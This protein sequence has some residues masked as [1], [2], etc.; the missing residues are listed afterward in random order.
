MRLFMS[1]A[2]EDRDPAEQI[3]LALGP[4]H[5]VFFDRDALPPGGDF[6]TR[7]RAAIA[8]A[9]GMIF[10]ISPDSVQAGSYTLT[11]L[12][13]AR[14]NWGHPLGRVLPVM[15]RAT[16]FRTIPNFL[17]A[18]TILEAKG[19]LAAEIAAAVDKMW[20]PRPV[21]SG[22]SGF[23][24]LV[25]ASAQDLQAT[26]RGRRK[27][28]AQYLNEI[29]DLLID[30][31][32]VL[33]QG[34]IPHG[35]CAEILQSGERLINTIGDAVDPDDIAALR[36]Q[37]ET[38]YRVEYLLVDISDPEERALTLAE[39]ERAS[40]TFRAIARALEASPAAG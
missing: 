27:E 26:S 7:I 34:Q 5:R 23:A 17:K 31:Q 32:K 19:N 36:E 15:V 22:L 13:L 35:T 4:V 6:N 24:H 29:H 39:L 1:Y 2:S 12:E 20:S 18:V 3:A 37:L 38:A 9:D 40:G 21:I 11:E 25:G 16:D 14:E 10:L 30:A 28:I 33:E 8:D